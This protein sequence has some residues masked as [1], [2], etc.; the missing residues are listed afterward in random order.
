MTGTHLC[1]LLLVEEG[2]HEL[3]AQ[4][5]VLILQI[6]ASQAGTITGEPQAPGCFFPFFNHRKPFI[7]VPPQPAPSLLGSSAPVPCGSFQH[8]R[9]VW[10]WATPVG[11][12]S[13]FPFLTSHWG[14]GLPVM[15]SKHSF[16]RRTSALSLALLL[17]ALFLSGSGNL[18]LSL[19]FLGSCHCV[20]L[21]SLGVLFCPLVSVLWLCQSL[22][23]MSWRTWGEGRSHRFQNLP[24]VNCPSPS[25]SRRGTKGSN[26]L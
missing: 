14:L 6:S 18:S 8:Q 25:G 22:S 23:M 21:S 3:I 20:F 24:R 2:S 11:S 19:C 13:P 1:A 7:Y 10:L 12:P 4:A 15:L 26:L 17:D 9:G 5:G 16:S